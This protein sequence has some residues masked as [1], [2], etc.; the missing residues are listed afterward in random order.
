MIAVLIMCAPA[1]AAKKKKTK[2][3]VTHADLMNYYNRMCGNDE[4]VEMYIGTTAEEVKY[5]CRK[6]RHYIY[7]NNKHKKARAAR[8]K[9]KIYRKRQQRRK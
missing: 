9:H 4:D 5:N 2:P 1:H 3:S 8:N 6:I 7:L